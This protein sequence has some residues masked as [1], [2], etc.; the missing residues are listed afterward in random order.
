M[1]DSIASRRQLKALC[2]ELVDRYT[3]RQPVAER[4]GGCGWCGGLPHSKECLVGRMEA[5]L[6]AVDA[7]PV[8][9]QNPMWVRQLIAM[10]RE[11]ARSVPA[12]GDDAITATALYRCADELAHWDGAPLADATLGPD[13][14]CEECG[15]IFT[16]VQIEAED[17]TAWGH[18]CYGTARKGRVVCESHRPVVAVAAPPPQ[19]EEPWQDIST[20]SGHAYELLFSPAHSRVIG[21]HVT[22]DVWHLVGVGCVTNRSERPTHWMPLPQP[23][24]ARHT[25]QEAP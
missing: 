5:A 25:R 14:V 18:P 19:A 11:R 16:A 12:E 2:Q 7:P 15:H 22:G 13:R 20:Y 24:T 9:P 1:T 21:A 10:W 3:K 23:P 6:L 17:P 8:T 4:H